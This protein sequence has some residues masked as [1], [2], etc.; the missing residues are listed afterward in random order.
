MKKRKL[1]RKALEHPELFSPGE[2]AYFELWLRARKE[3]KSQQKQQRKEHLEK[4]YKM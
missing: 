4:V 1:A 2:L 3:R